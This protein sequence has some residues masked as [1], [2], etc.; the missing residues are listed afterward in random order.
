MSRHNAAQT[1]RELASTVE[2]DPARVPEL[3]QRARGDAAGL[4]ADLRDLDPRQ[5]WGRMN[6]W[7]TA[8]PE[9]LMACCWLLA[10]MVPVDD[11]TQDELLAWVD[12]LAEQ[13]KAA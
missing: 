4:A 13:R 8:D 6:L 9:R 12:R 5:V 10:A 11:A 3:V 2:V 7:R 1:A